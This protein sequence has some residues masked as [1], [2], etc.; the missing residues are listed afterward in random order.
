[1]AELTKE[2]IDKAK[3]VNLYD[4]LLSHYPSD[5]E[6]A[7]DSPDIDPAGK[8][9]CEKNPDLKLLKPQGKDWNADLVDLRKR[10]NAYD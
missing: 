7:G 2:L 6:K 1:M 10:G 3:A 5:V 4:Y 9:C 8:K